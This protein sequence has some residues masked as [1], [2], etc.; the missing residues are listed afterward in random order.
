MAINLPQTSTNA[1]YPLFT[2]QP[3]L[4]SGSGAYLVYQGIGTKWENAK[5]NSSTY[6]TYT[7]TIGA[8]GAIG[9]VVIDN[10][11]IAL[12]AGGNASLL[13]RTVSTTQTINYST[14]YVT[15]FV[16]GFSAENI[17]ITSASWT[18]FRST[19]SLNGAGNMQEA[20]WQD[21]NGRCYRATVIIGSSYIKNTITVERLSSI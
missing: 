14:H 2:G 13:I 1:G 5:L 17:S 9:E 7:S 19:W 11:R 4:V 18:F 20:V 8:G 15:S 16:G 3:F 12:N 6:K 21:N 10:Y